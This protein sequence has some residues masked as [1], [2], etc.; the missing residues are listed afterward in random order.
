MERRIELICD[1]AASGQRLDQLLADQLPDVHR[2]QLRSRL[3]QPTVN[4]RAA[5]PSTRVRSGDHIRATLRD[6]EPPAVQ[7]EAIE[8]DIIDETPE[9]LVVNKPQGMVVHPGAGNHHGTL[10]HALVGRYGDQFLNVGDDDTRIQRPG[11]VHRLD[12]E[13]SG[14]MI[15]ARTPATHALLVGRFAERAVRKVYLA[16]VKGQPRRR[17]GVLSAAI[18]RHRHHRIRFAVHGEASHVPTGVEPA[19][20]PVPNGARA[21]TT[22]YR[23][24][25]FYREGYALVEL[26]PRTGRTHQLRVHMQHLGLPILGDPLYARA[27]A[28]FP[29]ARMMLHARELSLQ[30]DR[31]SSMRSFSAPV[32]RRFRDVLRELTPDPGLAYISLRNG[33]RD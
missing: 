21:A 13:T 8:L 26:K 31:A 33:S 25:Q 28:R 30:P 17:A 1:E 4:G 2:S 9:Y 11:I 23:V 10:V 32:P 3:E 7:G 5:K 16:I 15:V 27:D 22:Q 14:V 29:D 12:R 20:P 19:D 6:P 18:G 24:L